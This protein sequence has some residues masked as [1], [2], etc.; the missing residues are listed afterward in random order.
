MHLRFSD[1]DEAFRREVAAWL[2][3]RAR[4]RVRVR[5]A[6]AAAPATSTRCFD[7]RRAWERSSA[8]PAG[9]ASAGRASTAAAARRST[10][11]VI[12]YEEYA[13]AGGPGPARPHRRGPA[14][15]DAHRLR[16]R[17]AEAALPAARSSRGDEIWCQG[18]S[19]PERR[20]RPR[21]RA[22]ARRARRRRVGDRRPEGVDLARALG[23]LVLRALPHRPDAPKHKGLSYLLVPMRPAGHRDPPDR[24]DH[25][26]LASSTRSFFDG[27]RTAAA[28]V[29][30]AAGRRLEGRDGHARVR[31][32]R[33]DARPA[34]QLRERAR[35]RSSTI[36]QRERRARRSR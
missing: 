13:R 4:R 18:Y 26:R 25:R 6:V 19:E 9:P 1:E 36:A 28:N 10:Q 8:R 3:R 34:A 33:L 22:D 12:F 16:H 24:A 29:V 21:Q 20:L 15:P 27:A 11:Q 31:A 7:E 30:G 35:S 5:C 17:R 23:R 32:R 14:R 2:D